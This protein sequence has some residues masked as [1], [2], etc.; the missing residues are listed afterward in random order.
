MALTKIPGELFSVG[1][2]DISDVG[3]ISLDA[4]EGDADS[5]TSI[6]FSGSD[7]ITIATGGS[8]RLTIG[9]GALSPVTDNQIDLGTSSLEFKDAFF[10]GTVTSDAFAGP[11]TGDVTG[12]VSGTA[13]TVTGAA[14]SNITSLGTL[15]TLTVDNVIVNG[16]TI[17]HTSDT[18]LMT[19]ADGVLT[20]AGE[21]DATSLDISGD[22][23]V[24]GTLETDNLTVGGAQGSDGQ[25]L[26]ST[27]S[28][29][30]WETPSSFNADAAQTFNDS[31]AAVDFR[32]EGDTDANLFF[33][34]GSEDKIGIGTNAP[35]SK[36]HLEN[37]AS[38]AVVQIGFENDAQEW[39]LGVHGGL[40][41]GFLLYDN[42]NSASRFFVGTDG[43]IGIGLTAPTFATGNG[44]HFADSFY[45]GL[46]TG[47][48]T[49][50]DFSLSGNNSG[51]AIACGTGS[52]D[53]DILISTAGVMAVPNGIE[54]GS[55]TDFTS[56]NTLNDY[57][58]GTWTPTVGG[59]T[60]QGSTSSGSV[61]GKYIKI[62]K[63]VFASFSI[64]NITIASASGHLKI[65]GFPF[66]NDGT[67]DRE[68]NGVM[69]VYGVNLEALG[70]NTSP[71]PAV[72]N[73][74]NTAF[75][76]QSKDDAAWSVVQVSNGS[77]QYFEGTITYITT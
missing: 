11:L 65:G 35:T 43:N 33:L 72:N 69:R 75:V 66:N 12:N 2:L 13:A 51:L 54:L 36:L 9:D 71:I 22:V 14:Q 44:M 53:A 45:V 40:S 68:A 76:L 1:D 56:A 41:D 63:L 74:T 18:D 55:G 50:P 25:V 62:G 52:D 32:I 15:T 34:D 42:T 10:D 31:G 29:V 47:N 64:V 3:T 67:N 21:V 38:N 17:G 30:A 4:I 73:D 37:S 23:D 60:G 46:G 57:E 48:G 70:S 24:D 77:G 58:E 8:N 39:R 5:N 20:V 28:G 61:A 27:G 6:T 16:T 59:N 7:V 19:L 26:T 49:R